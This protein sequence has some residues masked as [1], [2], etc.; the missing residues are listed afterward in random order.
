MVPVIYNAALHPGPVAGWPMRTAR[1]TNYSTSS[2][3][4]PSEA[5]ILPRTRCEASSPGIAATIRRR[6][7]HLER[8]G[9]AL[10][11][12]APPRLLYALPQGVRRLRPILPRPDAHRD[13]QH[14]G[15][16]GSRC[17]SLS[18][19][20]TRLH[21]DGDGPRRADPRACVLHAT[22][23]DRGAALRHWPRHP[24][25]RAAAERCAGDRDVAALRADPHGRDG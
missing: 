19:R 9:R 6:C 14:R 17:G 10:R 11:P 22:G 13:G 24:P 3:A 7:K 18:R 16:S 25:Q 12:R 8:D 15:R 1:P 20:A 2:T 23:A 4:D 5:H 21:R